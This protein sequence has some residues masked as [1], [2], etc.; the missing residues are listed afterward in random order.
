MII[1]VNKKNKKLATPMISLETEFHADRS[2]YQTRR[3]VIEFVPCRTWLWQIALGCLS[4]Q[5]PVA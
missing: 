4:L 5:V 3:P 2:Y 1:K